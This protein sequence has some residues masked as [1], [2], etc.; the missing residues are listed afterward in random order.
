MS[1]GTQIKQFIR[2]Q[3]QIPLA[4]RRD[5]KKLS[6]L[7]GAISIIQM[8]LLELTGRD[9]YTEMPFAFVGERAT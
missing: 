1:G 8:T 5:L 6:L 2:T 7:Y 3:P 9:V 4:P